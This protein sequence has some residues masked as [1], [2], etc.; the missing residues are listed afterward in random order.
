MTPE[1]QPKG[2]E[3]GHS[4]EFQ[5]GMVVD[6]QLGAT[7]QLGRRG[8]DWYAQEGFMAAVV[9]IAPRGSR[10]EKSLFKNISGHDVTLYREPETTD[11][12]NN[13]LFST[14]TDWVQKHKQT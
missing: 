14:T 3:G 5:P 12:K 2:K 6:V 1:G 8:Q 9:R 13:W 11:L 10:R 7:I 4:G